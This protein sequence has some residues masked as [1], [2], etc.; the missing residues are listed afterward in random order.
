M[1]SIYSVMSDLFFLYFTTHAQEYW[2]P[3]DNPQHLKKE[4]Y[5]MRIKIFFMLM[6]GVFLML[7]HNFTFGQ[8]KSQVNQPM[9][10]WDEYRVES[11]PQTMEY[12]TSETTEIFGPN[13]FR[14]LS[15]TIDLPFNFTYIDQSYNQI[16]VSSNGFLT[17]DVSATHHYFPNNLSAVNPKNALAPLWDNLKVSSSGIVHYQTV[18][19]APNR[20]FIVEF[21]HVVWGPFSSPVVD[22]QIV[23]FEGSNDIEFHYGT[24]ADAGFGAS[25]AS[26]GIK[27]DKG[28]FI[29]ALD[30]SRDFPQ[31]KILEAPKTNFRFTY[32]PAPPNDVGVSDIIVDSN[33][34]VKNPDTVQVTVENHG[35]Q[36]QTGFIVAYLIEGGDPV[37]EIF[38]SPLSPGSKATMTFNTT[39]EP[40]QSGLYSVKAWTELDGDANSLNDSLLIENAI[41]VYELELPSPIN[42]QGATDEQNRIII[43]WNPGS[44]QRPLPGEWNGTT[45][46]GQN[47]HMILNYNSSTVDS[48][49]IYYTIYGRPFTFPLKTYSKRPITNNEFSF[50]YNDQYDRMSMDVHGTFIPADSCEGTWRAGVYVNN[51]YTVFSGTWE[52]TAEFETPKPVGFQV[53]RDVNPGVQPILANLVTEITDPLVT[54]YTDIQATAGIKYYYIVVINYGRG[55]SLPSTEVSVMVTSVADV[56]SSL[57]E[58]YCLYPAYP[59]PFNPQ[60]TIQYDLPNSEYVELKVYNIL[61]ER[62]ATLVHE[63]QH[64]G[65]YK[66]IFQADNFSSGVYYIALETGTYRSVKK[67]ILLK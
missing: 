48:C 31:N 53:Y 66:V 44:F 58:V 20:M 27:D 54:S 60:T 34:F 52:A 8:G 51:V 37:R 40:Q 24:I 14:E 3:R 10:T 35:S 61:G 12:L 49:E 9:Q 65:R 47:V 45:S 36:E 13:T 42:V 25:G 32:S 7:P 55:N 22:F 43:S 57:P 67:A 38:S 41:T 18:G 50:Y 5:K 56:S 11:L 19:S 29:N 17:F 26:I 21:Y 1:K 64:A 16:K 62:V 23:L 30:N 59:N 39:W 6:G 2:Y 15:S 63:R 46:E 28:N 33:W 4:V